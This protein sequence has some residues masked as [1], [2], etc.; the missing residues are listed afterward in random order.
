MLAIIQSNISDFTGMI[1]T[2]TIH[3][4][5]LISTSRYQKI[6]SEADNLREIIDSVLFKV[7]LRVDTVGSASVGFH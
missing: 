6:I 5:S 2:V 3:L 7:I 4:P 1:I